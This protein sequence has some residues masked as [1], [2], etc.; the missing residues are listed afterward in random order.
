MIHLRSK[1]VSD[2]RM[3]QTTIAG[4]QTLREQLFKVKA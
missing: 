3:L 4:S 1:A 2:R